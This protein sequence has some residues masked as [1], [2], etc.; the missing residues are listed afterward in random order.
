MTRLA[1]GALSPHLEY[2][3]AY[4]IRARHKGGVKYY[5]VFASRAKD[6]F[7]FMNDFICTEEDDLRLQAEIAARAPG[8][9]SLFGPVHEAERDI[10]MKDL[11]NEIHTYGLSHQGCTR[12][13]VIQDFVLRYFGDFMQK[14]Y[15]RLIDDLVREG[16]AE[17]GSG[18]DKDHRRITFK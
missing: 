7:V 10:H 11:I 5:L 9:Q 12:E 8:Q 16:R 13:Q 15:R 18:K 1:H 14:H 4:P 17:F 3:L 2:G 6:G